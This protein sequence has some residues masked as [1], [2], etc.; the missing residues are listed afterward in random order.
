MSATLTKLGHSCVRI[1]DGDR[2]LV[3]DPGVFSDAARA[4]EGADAVLITHEH[5]DHI[6][7]DVVRGL[8]IPVYAPARRGRPGAPS[9]SPGR[10]STSRGSGCRPSGASTR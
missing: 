2:T 5:P 8:E 3:I 1:T 7:A 9:S 4:V 6:D 10:P